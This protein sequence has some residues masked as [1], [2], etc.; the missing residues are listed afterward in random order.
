MEQQLE[1]QTQPAWISLNFE[2]MSA[3]LD[4]HLADFQSMV[5]TPDN[6]KDAKKAATEL[7][8][9]AN[10]IDQ[11]RKDAVREV[12]KPIKEFDSQAKTL[13]GKCKDVRQSLLDQVDIYESQVREQARQL[14]DER[15]AS[16]WDDANV[17]DEFRQAKIDDLVK[18]SAVTDKGNLSKSAREAIEARVK[19]DRALQD[20]V[21]RRLLELERDCYAAGLDT[22]LARQHVEHFLYA[23]DDTYREQLQKMI[24]TEV[25]R[26]QK[27]EARRRQ[28]AERE[29][30]VAAETQAET[31]RQDAAEAKQADVQAAVAQAEQAAP[32]AEDAPDDS[33]QWRVTIVFEV[34]T[35]RA[36]N[37][38]VDQLK[39]HVGARLK[40]AGIPAPSY[41]EAHQ[42]EAEHVDA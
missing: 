12:S 17:D 10:D 7:N 42:T 11:R 32:A 30:A 3:A 4:A 18:L 6:I 15:R 29:A 22:P 35:P 2:E 31:Q 14:L 8:K 36:K 37:I 13:H 33:Q 25:E 19:D 5:V 28:M 9:L 39:Q 24:A 40:D 41:I 21:E 26:Q 20:K 34:A 23:D 16:L 27:A 38:S 1:I